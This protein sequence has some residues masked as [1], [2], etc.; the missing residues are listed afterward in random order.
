MKLR[1]QP[2]LLLLTVLI[3]GALGAMQFACKKSAQGDD[4][5][6]AVTIVNPPLGAEANVPEEKYDYSDAISVTLLMTNNVQ[7][8][9]EP[10]G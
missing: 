1:V 9:S 2:S 10:C 5:N 3:L 7:G 6:P 4:A 8:E